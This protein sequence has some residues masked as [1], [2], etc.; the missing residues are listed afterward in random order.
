[1]KDLDLFL[2]FIMPE[3]PGCPEPRA[4]RAIR[5][6]AREA[7]RGLRL[8]RETDEVEI[9]APEY[10]AIT[11]IPEA[12]IFEIEWAR[13]DGTKLTPKTLQWLD[14]ERDGWQLNETAA[15]AEFITQLAPATVSI[16]PRQTGQL[17]MR[18]VLIPSQTTME[19][20]D[21]LY[22]SHAEELGGGA[23]ASILSDVAQEYSNPGRALDLR[24]TFQN[25]LAGEQARA[26]RGQQRSKV[27]TKPNF[28]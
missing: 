2:P 8:W 9:T 21:F 14:D 5:H 27:R 11:T 20:P 12:E 6:A 3:A 16:Y 13:L 18:L 1:M 19:L 26:F 28:F 7:C 10:Q 24:A 17:H 25:W 4:L 23:L 15:P 22:D